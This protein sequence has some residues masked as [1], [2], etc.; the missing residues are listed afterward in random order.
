MGVNQK[1]QGG[2]SIKPRTTIEQIRNYSNYLSR[3]NKVDLP[4]D[5]LRLVRAYAQETCDERGT[6]AKLGMISCC[7]HCFVDRVLVPDM[8][9]RSGDNF[10]VSWV[11]KESHR[12]MEE[13]KG[14]G[15]NKE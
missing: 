13:K 3:Y 7:T 2:E 9:A 8:I 11:A 10:I 1:P 6:C 5:M 15:V 4:A 14:R 12:D